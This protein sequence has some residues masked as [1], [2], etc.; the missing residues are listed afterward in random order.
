MYGTPISFGGFVTDNFGL[1]FGTLDF[2]NNGFTFGD[3]VG[4][5]PMSQSCKDALRNLNSQ[6]LQFIGGL[7]TTYA[8][9]RVHI[10]AGL[11]LAAGDLSFLQQLN[12]AQDQVDRECAGQGAGRNPNGPLPSGYHPASIRR[13][14]R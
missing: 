9:G 7:L 12:L 2:A 11:G 10:V 1:D 3:V 6:F 13:Q 4:Y 8:G 5:P 14:A